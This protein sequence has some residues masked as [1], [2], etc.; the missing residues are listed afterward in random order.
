MEKIIRVG[1]MNNFNFTDNEIF[2]LKKYEKEGK[3]FVNSNSFVEIKADYPSIITI[4]P[5]LK[6]VEP[7]GDLTNIK[8]CRV[9]VI[10]G[11]NE[12]TNKEQIEAIEWCFNN[13]IPVLITWMRFSKRDTM[14]KYTTNNE[15]HY[16]YKK[17]YFRLKKESKN[18]FIDYL[19]NTYPDFT[20]LIFQC[21]EKEEGCPSCM[22]CIRLTYGE[23]YVDK[24]SLIGLNLTC[25]GNNGK[26]IFNCPDCWSKRLLM[27]HTPACDKLVK[28][29]KQTGKL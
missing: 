4:N 25:S 28:N 12:Q 19:K 20:D 6:F 13:N 11:A 16:E 10:V 1:V 23:Q 21:D 9:K 5:Y 24:G 3:L 15:L 22:N 17:S 18:I 7:A 14:N 29:K 2:E 8:A 27:G 26:C